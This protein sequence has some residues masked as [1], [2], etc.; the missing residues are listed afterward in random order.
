MDDAVRGRP[1]VLLV[2]T[3]D[4]AQT[5]DALRRQLAEVADI[6]AWSDQRETARST[7]P[8]ATIAELLAQTRLHDF[9]V[10]VL[11]NG[12]LAARRAARRATVLFEAG[13]LIGA[14][15][16]ERSVVVLAPGTRA[17]S[18]RLPGD[19]FDGTFAQ[20]WFAPENLEAGLAAAAGAIKAL[21]AERWAAA[22]PALLPS[23]GVAIGYFRN[24]VK[25][26]CDYLAGDEV[27]IG[28][29]R[30]AGKDFDFTFEIVIPAT[31]EDA[32]PDGQQ[33]FWAR[34]ASR[35]TDR[36]LT[37][38]RRYPFFIRTGPSANP[39]R[40]VD[41]PT[42]LAASVDA[43]AMVLRGESQGRDET[44]SLLGAREIE[45]FAITFAA[46]IAADP[47]AASHV[48]LRRFGSDEDLGWD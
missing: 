28:D 39:L 33:R 12:G 47:A 21:L 3:T 10:L 46:L 13:L 34:N 41:Y 24:F 44:R 35:L 42:P 29:Q 18:L 11:G 37:L 26:V 38:G 20:A 32:L 43:V 5:A 27:A 7:A 9:L 6:T 45:N 14:L 4:A 22:A 19:L 1:R 48:R 40:V 23:T 8:G 31:L 15:G 2:S 17:G 16:G 25:P 36:S 30:F